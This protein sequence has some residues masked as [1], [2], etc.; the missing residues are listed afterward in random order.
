MSAR[1]SQVPWLPSGQETSRVEDP[2]TGQGGA[3][4]D[5]NPALRP[6]QSGSA[7]SLGGPASKRFDTEDG[8]VEGVVS[9]G[10][11]RLAG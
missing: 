11:V 6:W 1:H 2:T 8:G 7:A 9:A 5:L 4:Q 3:G 10:E